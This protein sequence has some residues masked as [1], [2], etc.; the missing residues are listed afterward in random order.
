MQ[1]LIEMGFPRAQCDK[2]VEATK[3]TNVDDAVAWIV[4]NKP[5][6]TQKIKKKKNKSIIFT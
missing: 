3:A 2:A 1:K 6:R 4:N 5:V